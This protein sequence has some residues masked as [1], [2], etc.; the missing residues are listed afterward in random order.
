MLE[1]VQAI[2]EKV[3]TLV[4]WVL[5]MKTLTQNPYSSGLNV[6][7]VLEDLGNFAAD[8]TKDLYNLEEKLKAPQEEEEKEKEESKKA[9]STSAKQ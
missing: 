1:D 7:R 4:N 3:G 5:E 9:E 2:Q 6:P 8:L